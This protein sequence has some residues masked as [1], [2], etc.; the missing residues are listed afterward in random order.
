MDPLLG[1]IALKPSGR[2]HRQRE[3]R[4]NKSTKQNCGDKQ[5]Q[6]IADLT[7]KN[8]LPVI[9]PWREFVAAGGLMSYGQDIADSFR[10]AATYV[11]KILKGAK[12]GELPIEQPTRIHLAVNRKTA[13]AFGL[14]IPQELLLRADELID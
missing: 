13:N 5:R 11:D 6:Q 10:R 9:A 4:K 3:R 2:D 1:N 8:R 14:T 7:V 12:P